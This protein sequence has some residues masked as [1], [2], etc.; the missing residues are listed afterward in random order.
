MQT[1]GANALKFYMS[2]METTE[3]VDE[4]VKAVDYYS[5][6]YPGN[7]H[8]EELRWVLAERMRVLSQQASPDAAALRREANQQFQQLVDSNGTFADKG[9][10]ALKGI[11]PVPSAQEP[12]A[13]RH[14]AS[15]SKP[16][17]DEIQIIS[18]SGTEVI[19]APAVPH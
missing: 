9:R 13:R 6:V 14:A 16:K 1:E 15:R 10:D 12:R 11:E 8:G 3:S 18:G 5:K 4:A 19:T 7:A 2:G 17:S